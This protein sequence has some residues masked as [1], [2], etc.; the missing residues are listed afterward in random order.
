MLIDR[1]DRPTTEQAGFVAE[2]QPFSYALLA[3]EHTG[4]SNSAG[5]REW[6]SGQSKIISMVVNPPGIAFFHGLPGDTANALFV[7][8]G[9]IHVRR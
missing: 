1:S 4:D 3:T 6:G 9:I 8:G 7:A 2:L 5:Q